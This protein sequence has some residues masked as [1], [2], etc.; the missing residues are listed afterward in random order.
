MEDERALR[1]P[2]PPRSVCLSVKGGMNELMSGLG[3]RYLFSS[4]V[5]YGISV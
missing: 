5:G 4:L 1:V 3:N 2:F